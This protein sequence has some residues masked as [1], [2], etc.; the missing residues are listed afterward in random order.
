M[1]LEEDIALVKKALSNDR[2]AHKA[3]FDKYSK[4]MYH[5]ALTYTASR[6]EAKDIVQESFIKVFE[7]L[8]KYDQKGS[9]HAW[10]KTIVRNTSIDYFRKRRRLEFVSAEDISIANEE[11]EENSYPFIGLDRILALVGKLPT[12]SR[13]VFNMYVLENMTHK[14]IARLLDINE[15]TSKSQYSRAKVLLQQMILKEVG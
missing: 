14:E 11:P 3:L 6:D 9:F 1:A 10:V 5:L 8:K 15:G 7:G 13:L 12:G 2:S 4:E